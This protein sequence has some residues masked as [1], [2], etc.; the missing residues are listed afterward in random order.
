M[1]KGWM[2]KEDKK[3]LADMKKEVMKEVRDHPDPARERMMCKCGHPVSNHYT[4]NR[5]MPCGKCSCNW[6]TAPVAEQLRRDMARSGVQDVH[7][8]SAFRRGK[9]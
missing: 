5:A 3:W 8:H 4:L 2:T 1:S 9:G 6:C 7:P